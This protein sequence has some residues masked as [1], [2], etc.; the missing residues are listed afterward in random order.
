[1]RFIKLKKKLWLPFPENESG[2]L[3]L[4]TSFFFITAH[5]LSGDIPVVWPD[6][7][8]FYNPAEE[9]F[10]HGVMRTT[11]LSGLI[12]GMERVTFWM[13]PLFIISLAA[14]FSVFGE[15]LYV[16]RMFS[17]VLSF[18][19]VLLVY[20]IAKSL[21]LKKGRILVPILFVTDFLFIRVSHSSRME[22]MTMLLGLLAIYIIL[23]NSAWLQDPVKPLLAGFFSGLAFL[24]HPF[25]AVYGVVGLASLFYKKNAK[26]IFY[27]I[28]A[29]MLP[30]A[31]WVYYIYPETDL[32]KI[33]FGAQLARKKELLATFTLFDKFKILL[34]GYRFSYMKLLQIFISGLGVIYIFHAVKKDRVFQFLVFWLLFLV[35]AV[36]FSTEIWYLVHIIPPFYLVLLYILQKEKKH[37]SWPIGASVAMNL[38]LVFWLFYSNFYLINA[39][40]KTAEFYNLMADEIGSRKKIYLQSIPDPWFYFKSRF[41]DKEF[42]EFIPG[43]LPIDE[44]FYMPE[45]QKQDVFIFY[46]PKLMNSAIRKFLLENKHEFIE[47][48]VEVLTGYDKDL[49]LRA[50]M[51]IKRVD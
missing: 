9:L 33:Q 3:I 50:S 22:G 21:E 32:L 1:M 8:L 5:I 35:V 14:V 39:K 46:D 23:E 45:I 28:S 49:R 4:L 11:V 37:T 20:Q 40:Q 29:G 48:N 27:F 6:E 18:A 41:P 12:P 34:S 31:G 17:S 51:Y 19:A 43:E 42:R 44:T 2:I 16:A 30:L 38:F 7:V 26:S 10:R 25:G 36:F 13:P 47:K 15:S 24:S